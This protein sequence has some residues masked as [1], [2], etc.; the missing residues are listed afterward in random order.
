MQ[1]V[2]TLADSRGPWD[3]RGVKEYITEVS[4]DECLRGRTEAG[5]DRR[6]AHS[7][8]T[9]KDV[10]MV[11]VAAVS[12]RDGKHYVYVQNN[13]FEKREVKVGE[14]NEKFIAIQDGVKE[15]DKVALNTRKRLA[16]EAKQSG[17]AGPAKT[18][19]APAAAGAADRGRSGE[20][21]SSS[22]AVSTPS[23]LAGEGWGGGRCDRAHPARRLGR[24]LAL[25]GPSRVLD[26]DHRA[27]RAYPPP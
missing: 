18:P 12:E 19:T 3:E 26:E 10:L 5:H 27:A 15:G 22:L 20:V 16:D 21:I 4:I 1:N 14:S 8:G 6:G 7:R 24:S 11:P 9:Y 25:P 17:E 23:P 13:G 2:A